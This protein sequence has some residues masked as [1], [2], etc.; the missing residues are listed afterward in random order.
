MNNGELTRKQAMFCREYL[1]DFNATQAAIR[2]GY[3]TETAYSIGNENLRKPKIRKCIR[4]LV[5]AR[6]TRTLVAADRVLG[7]LAEIAFGQFTVANRDRLRALDMLAKHVGI[8]DRQSYEYPEFLSESVKLNRFWDSIPDKYKC[9]FSIC[10]LLGPEERESISQALEEIDRRHDGPPGSN[11]EEYTGR[12]LKTPSGMIEFMKDTLG[13]ARIKRSIK[14]VLDGLLTKE[15]R[16]PT[17]M[18]EGDRINNWMVKEIAGDWLVNGDSEGDSCRRDTAPPTPSD[19]AAPR[20]TP[21]SNRTKKQHSA[22]GQRKATTTLS[23]DA[24][25]RRIPGSKRKKMQHSDSG[26]RKATTTLSDDAAPRRTQGSKRKKM[27]HS[28]SGQRKATT[29]QSDDAAP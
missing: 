4:E 2:A 17:R 5:A 6:N 29:T 20:K 14:S 7:K 23:D 10:N 19:D 12:D 8:Y 15:Q 26:Q 1:L 24:A 27:Q 22:S 18:V 28:A 9:V 11:N 3:S 13:A 21:G 25:P 16:L